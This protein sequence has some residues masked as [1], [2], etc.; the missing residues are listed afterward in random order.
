[1]QQGLNLLPWRLQQHKTRLHYFAYQCLALGILILLSYVFLFQ[2]QNSLKQT[3]QGYQ[4]QLNVI[5]SQQQQISSQLQHLRQDYVSV[6]R[7]PLVLE[8]LKELLVLITHL[9][10]QQ[11][12]LSAVSLSAEK[13]VITGQVEEQAEFE[14]L[15]QVLKQT[16]IFEQVKLIEFQP[17][18]QHIL[19]Q[20]ELPLKEE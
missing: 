13:L 10:L 16:N 11:G 17:Q 20:L 18:A 12:E 6:S 15:H 7:Q 2:W 14:R 1:M 4:Q 9:P 19:F 8:K 3:A 5:S